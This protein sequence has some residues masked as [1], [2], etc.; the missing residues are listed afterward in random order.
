MGITSLLIT[1]RT[2]VILSTRAYYFPISDYLTIC[3]SHTYATAI[4][5]RFNVRMGRHRCNFMPENMFGSRSI[6]KSK[7]D[8]HL[9][10][11]LLF[12]F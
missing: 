8:D 9:Q 7:D 6:R 4:F 1:L 5:I 11:R 12:L 3:F 2:L 10:A